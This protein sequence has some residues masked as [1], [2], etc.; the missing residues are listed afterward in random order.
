MG[1]K[2]LF[3]HKENREKPFGTQAANR[4]SFLSSGRPSHS[5][6]SRDPLPSFLTK[7][8]LGTPCEEI[9]ELK[10]MAEMPVRGKQKVRDTGVPLQRQAAEAV[11]EVPKRFKQKTGQRKKPIKSNQ[12]AR[13]YG[14]IYRWVYE[15]VRL[16][17]SKMSIVSLV[18]GLLF[19]GTLFFIIGFLA[20]VATIG[21]SPSG[22]GNPPSTTWQA[23]NEKKGKGFE[24]VMSGLVGKAAGQ[25]IGS[26]GKIVGT[27]S[28]IP[29]SLQPFARYGMGKVQGEIRRDVRQVNP[30]VS[31]RR[32]APLPEQQSYGPQQP[33][34]YVSPY[35]FQGG[36]PQQG[37]AYGPPPTAVGY[38]QPASVPQSGYNP[39][40]LPP[41][42]QQMMQQPYYPQAMQQQAYQQPQMQPMM[43]QQPMMPGPQY[44]QQMPPQQGYYR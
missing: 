33:Q 6:V 9:V 31:Q 25:Q 15:E 26:L 42:Q 20:A 32:R 36:S 3:Q 34:Q 11:R 43:P 13:A 2:N 22:G 21:P 39:G 35:G 17:M 28:V 24:R 44:Q 38:Q 10:S 41:Q 40:Y 1:L 29:K 16:S 23:S 19:L 7:T 18:L 4:S 12:G 37:Q 14:F 30:F 8:P 5:S 27:S